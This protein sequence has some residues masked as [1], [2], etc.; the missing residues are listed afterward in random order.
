[1]A[2][3]VKCIALALISIIFTLSF[4][5]AQAQTV[6]A[7]VVASNLQ[8]PWAVAFLPGGRF[9]VT[10]RPGRL[11]VIEPNGEMGEPV[12]GLPSMAAQG[13]GGLLDVLLDTDFVNNNT[14]YFCFS[15]PGQGGNSTALAK[16]RLSS[17]R[18]RL[19]D[20]KVIFSQQPKV[21]SSAHFGCRIVER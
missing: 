17:D 3:N 5:L 8:N 10:E 7:E 1:M 21:V 14:L 9:L 2:R 18:L 13:Q 4:S 19:E 12:L 15:E 16:A 6:R 20:L 11:R